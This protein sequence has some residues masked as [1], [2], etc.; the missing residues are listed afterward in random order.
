MK[1]AR[2]SSRRYSHDCGK[3]RPGQ[4]RTGTVTM[5]YFKSVA[6]YVFAGFLLSRDLR[7]CNY[8]IQTVD[9]ATGIHM[10]ARN[11]VK[12]RK[13]SSYVSYVF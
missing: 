4:D 1:R 7:F 13:I 3:D 12:D 10:M 8:K 5:T 11:T 9:P 2:R 6:G